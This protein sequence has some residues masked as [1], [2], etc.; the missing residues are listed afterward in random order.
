MVVPGNPLPYM[1]VIVM[2]DRV[3]VKKNILG[4]PGE[5]WAEAVR[6]K[7]QDIGVMTLRGFVRN[8]PRINRMLYDA[9]HSQLHHTTL[10]MMLKETCDIWFGDDG[11]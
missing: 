1:P 11:G 9:G 7:F 4:P 10:N 3:A 6:S 2:L 5:A 8:A